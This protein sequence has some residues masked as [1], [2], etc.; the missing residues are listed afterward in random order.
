[1]VFVP[2]VE[3]GLLVL[4]VDVR[5]FLCLRWC[6]FVVVVLVEELWSPAPLVLD[7]PEAVVELLPLCPL[8]LD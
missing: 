6:F 4:S 8:P 7:C 5:L 2:E 3:L 1:L